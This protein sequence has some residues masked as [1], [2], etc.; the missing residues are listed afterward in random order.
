MKDIEGKVRFIRLNNGEDIIAFAY[1]VPKDS[2]EEG[3]YILND[4]LKIVYLSSGNPSKPTMSI[5][6]MQWIFSR[7]TNDKDYKI[8][9]RDVLLSSEPTESLIDFYYKTVDH[10]EKVKEEQ[11]KAIQF[12]NEEDEEYG[13]FDGEDY[14]DESEGLQMIRDMLQGLKLDKKKLN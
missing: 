14:I 10:F 12:T 2:V 1:H 9:E 7:I 11:K 3:H 13:E 6:L 8:I 5:S 4:P